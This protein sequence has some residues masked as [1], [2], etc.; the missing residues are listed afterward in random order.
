MA[1][2]TA[3]QRQAQARNEYDAFIKDCPTNQLLGRLGDKWAGLVVCALAPGPLRYS[4]LARKLAGVSPKM[5]TQTLRALERDGILTRELT[6]AV[7]IRVDYE[8]TP[9]GHSLAH[10]LTAVKTW[11]E[12]HMDEVHAAR[13][14]YDTEE[15]HGTG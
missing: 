11:A 3:A 1:T 7:P 9:L 14:N 4:G 12:T 6:P 8:L 13:Q 15:T 5:L 10:L 2:T